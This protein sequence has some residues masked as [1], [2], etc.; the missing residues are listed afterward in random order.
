VTPQLWIWLAFVFAFGACIGSFLNVVIYRMPRD[1]SLVYPPS[2]CPSC[3]K[4][5]RFYHNI[6]IFSW[7]LL[8]GKCRYCGAP[9]SPR[10]FVIELMT[11]LMYVGLFW[12]YF[13]TP[14]RQMSTDPISGL[15]MFI[16]GGWFVFVLHI[17]LLS[18][19]VAVSAI[20][21]ELWVVPLSAC[22]FLT[23]VGVI[24]S[25]LA[26]YAID[27]R[28]IGYHQLLPLS[29]ATTG[30]VS[31]GA[32]IGLAISLTLLWKGVFKESY[33]MQDAHAG[34]D[35]PEPVYNHRR[36]ILKEI[37]FVTP[38]VVCAIA[39]WYLLTKVPAMHSRWLSVMQHPIAAGFFGSLTGYF[40]G[41][42]IVWATRIFGTLA[43]GK[44]AMGMGDVHLM[45]AAG[46]FVGPIP[47][48]VAFF[49]APF[50]GLAWAVFQMLSK[51]TREI[52]YVPFLSLGI[53]T[54]MIFHDW[55]FQ[56]LRS[57]MVH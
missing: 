32:A 11:G 37:C 24:G 57:L 16:Q 41:G 39:G 26:S 44:E 38:I 43:F 50:F 5:I 18:G 40:M 17:A 34:K 33:P 9:I 56:R 1:L 20:D 29:G 42:A 3:G 55:I 15:Q 48:T 4:Y 25:A 35:V 8:R 52:P 7:L 31:A 22:W 12:L 54:V 53:L 28:Q 45:G 19:L 27:I 2:A 14:I 23:A 46:A 10:Y 21:L 30:A 36:E 49:I 6:P 47:I 51:K 13:M